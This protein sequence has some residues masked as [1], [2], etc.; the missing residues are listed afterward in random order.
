MPLQYAN[1]DPATRGHALAEL[2]RDIA[3]G[4]FHVSERL[5]P[6]VVADYQRLLREAIRYYDDLWL[7]E[8]V[9]DLLIEFEPRRTRSGGTTTARVPEM[10]GRLLAEHDFNNYYMRG[11]CVR[12]IEEGREVVEVYRARLSIAPRAQSAELEGHRISARD[13]LTQLRSE[14]GDDLPIS[15]LALGRYNSGLS[16]R[17]V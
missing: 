5:R 9:D 12:A 2:D 7:E 16:V 8:R 15:T 10:A 3:D 1:L 13:V 17:L 11:V 6:T 4:T 14:P